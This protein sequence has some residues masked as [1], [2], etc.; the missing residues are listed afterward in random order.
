[1][2]SFTCD[3]AAQDLTQTI[4]VIS[5]DVVEFVDGKEYVVESC[6][7]TRCLNRVKAKAEGGVGAYQNTCVRCHEIDKGLHLLR[8]GSIFGPRQAQVPA[9]FDLPVG[10]EPVTRQVGRAKR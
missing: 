6:D 1:M 7:T 8:G 4:V 3:N 2:G 5:R 10:F 9:I